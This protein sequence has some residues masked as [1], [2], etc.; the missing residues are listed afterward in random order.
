MLLFVA[1]IKTFGQTYNVLQT[2][3]NGGTGSDSCWTGY[4]ASSMP[5][6]NDFFTG[7][8]VV[9]SGTHSGG[10]Y[11]CCGGSATNTP[12]YYISPVL[13]AGTHNVLAYLRQSSF[14]GE[15]FEIGTV[16]DLMGSGW[17]LS[18][19]KS[20]WPG[21]PAWELTNISVTTTATNK[22]IAFRVPAA[23]LKTY[24]LDSLVISNSG[25]ANVACSYLS[26]TGIADIAITNH[27]VVVS[28]NP[29]TTQ[30]TITFNEVQ[31]NAKIKVLDVLGKEIYNAA[32]PENTKTYTLEEKNWS[33]G[34]YFLQ[35]V[36]D[37]ET[38]TRKIVKE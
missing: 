14:F 10:M 31:K 35:I 20:T 33:K 21:T 18:Y 16:S 4:N 26:S 13:P 34:I 22:Y 1:T 32:I 28:P 11:S 5:T 3:E 37:K 24:Y 15:S 12:T 17:M 38:L 30:A 29:F 7:T 8:T 9:Q 27:T 25:N 19:T 2:F 23:S 6:T 36:S